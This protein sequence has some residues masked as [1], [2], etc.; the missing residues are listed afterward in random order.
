MNYEILII[1]TSYK[2]TH[3]VIGKDALDLQQI[4]VVTELEL[5]SGQLYLENDDYN[6]YFS[7]L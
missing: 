2:N 5:T 7:A 6:I 3:I 1:V 4:T